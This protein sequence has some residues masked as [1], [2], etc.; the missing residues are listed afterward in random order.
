MKI[1]IYLISFTA[2]LISQSNFACDVFTT[3]CLSGSQV[4]NERI[5]M[6]IIS[7][8]TTNSVDINIIDVLFG[9]ENSTS[10][11][12][13]DGTTIECNGPW[14]NDANDMGN[15]GDTILC[16]IEPITTIENT[17]DVI[18]DYRRPSL[19]GG[20]TYANFSIGWLF[21]GTYNYEEVLELDFGTHCCNNLIQILTLDIYGLP[22]STGSYAPI[23][24]NAYPQG[25]TFSGPGIIFSAF[26]P[27]IAG[28][29]IHTI[30]YTIND[31]FGCSFS[32]Q[33]DIFVFTI[34]FNFVN[35]SLGTVAPRL[36]NAIDIQL[37]VPKPGNYTFKI[38]D[39][40]GKLIYTEKEHFKTGVHFKSI[41]PKKSL[42]NGI[43]M[44]NIGNDETTVTKKFVV[45]E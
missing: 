2:F 37:E 41:S 32:T 3:F 24:L 30:T 42:P 35:Y 19:L 15:I 34:D 18:G 31:E 28:P 12:I 20:D 5:V 1:K 13:W 17:W 27:S 39:L 4:N 23:N 10:V 8:S 7:N 25:G 9:V 22:V 45:G 40:I 26:N 21:E 38:F 29:G 43:F 36:A 16:M 6:G 44:L 11:T 33:K 14:P